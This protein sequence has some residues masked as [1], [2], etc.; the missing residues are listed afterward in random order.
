MKTPLLRRLA[1]AAALLASCGVLTAQTAQTAPTTPTTRACPPPP[2]APPAADSTPARDRG[3]L[4]KLTRD[5]RS[6]WLYASIHVGRPEW[7]RPGPTLEQALRDSDL[8][9]LEVDITSPDT[10]RQMAQAL[11]DVK[12]PALPDALRQ[13][14]QRLADRACLPTLAQDRLQQSHPAMQLMA[15]TI[16]EGLWEGL[17]P[18]YAQ[19]IALA[20]HARANNRSVVGLESVQAQL[21]ALLPPP[22]EPLLPQIDQAL[23]QLER[24]QLRPTLRRLAA[25]WEGGDLATI[26]DYPRWCNCLPDAAAQRALERLNDDRNPGLAAAIEALHQR[27]MKVFA[28]VGV[29]HMTGPQALP[30]L[31]QRMGFVVERV[32]L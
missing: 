30:L 4:W 20:L 18:T 32:P 31:L 22:G 21:A 15:L 8:V 17:A 24:D 19:E 26:A 25:A 1:L 7:L 2:P 11:A 9:A 16:V 28:A 3:L 6:S 12:V 5:G 29:L 13:R 14:I 10:A 27:D 23:D